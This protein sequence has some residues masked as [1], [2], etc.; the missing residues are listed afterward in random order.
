MPGYKYVEKDILGREMRTVGQVLE[1]VP[2]SN[3]ILNIDRRLQ[4]TIRDTLQAQMDEAG[5]D[6]GVTIA[7]NP[8]TGAILG[9]VSLPI[10]DNNIFAERV[11]LDAYQQL[12]DDKRLPLINYAIGGLYPP[13]STFK[14]VPALGALSEGVIDKNTRIIDTGPLLL[15]NQFFPDDLLQAQPFVSWNH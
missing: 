5:S 8:Q 1:P 15:P 10:F 7:M 2:G 3:L 11:D 14:L 6:W 13:G 12:V 4:A 9:L